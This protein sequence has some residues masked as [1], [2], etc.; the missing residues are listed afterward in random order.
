M[1][2]EIVHG[3]ALAVLKTLA[4]NSIDALVTDP[5]AGIEFMGAEWDTFKQGRLQNYKKQPGG[6]I[7][8]N[9][10]AGA[11]FS[12]RMAAN[13]NIANQKA[14]PK[15]KKCNKYA[16]DHPGRKCE[17]EIPDWQ[18]DHSARQ[19]FISFMRDVMAEALRCIKPGGH[20]LVWA[21]PRT[22][23]WTATALEDAGW[24]IRDVVTHLTGQ[25]F[26][27]SL[28]ID[29]A[30][31]K[32]L[33]AERTERE[34]Y[35]RYK[36]GGTR[37][38]QSVAHQNI[39]LA[40][41]RNGNYTTLPATPEA[42]QWAGYGSALKPAAENWIYCQ[43]PLD[44]LG[45]CDIIV[46]NLEKIR[47]ELLC[48][49]PAKTAVNPSQPTPQPSKKVRASSALSNAPT[50][51]EACHEPAIQTGEAGD[52]LPAMDMSE[53]ESVMTTCLSIVTSWSNILVALSQLESRFTI[54][55]V[56][57]L[58]TD[59]KTLNSLVSKITPAIIIQAVTHPS[60][61]SSPVFTVEILLSG[62]QAKL[63]AI[64]KLTAL[65]SATEQPKE[66]NENAPVSNAGL[67]SLPTHTSTECSAT[68][69]ATTSGEQPT[70]LQTP[71]PTGEKAAASEHWILCR[72]PLA[73]AN[74]ASNV[75]AW[76]TGGLNIDNTR[77][78]ASG[79][80]TRSHQ[81][82]YS[83]SGWRTGHE[84]IDLPAG[85]WPPNFLLS[86]SPL[87]QRVGTKQVKGSAPPGKPSRGKT[88]EDASM[89]GLP[90]NNEY[91][92]YTDADGMETVE[93]WEC[94]PECPVRLLDEQAGER[95]SGGKTQLSTIGFGRAENH[96]VDIPDIREPSSGPVSRFFPV[97]TP[98]MPVAYF[99]KASRRERNAGCEGLPIEAS[100]R[101][102]RM[103]GTPEHGAKHDTPEGNNHPTVK[104]LALMSW[105]VR[106][107]TPPDGTVLDC[108]AG[109]GSTLVACV[110][111]GFHY[112]GIEQSADYVEICKARVA[113]AV[114]NAPVTRQEAQ[115]TALP[116]KVIPMPRRKKNAVS[117]LQLSLFAQEVG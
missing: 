8:S 10:G 41:G 29:K 106:L 117:E 76:G 92:S 82:P 54:E 61:S 97:F 83:A 88:V 13:P 103:P 49:Y 2:D 99:P 46:A 16:W 23:H 19:T 66:S 9:A 39:P 47:S 31:D 35:D 5:P 74:L 84:V 43:K 27:K 101:Y 32:Q 20:A 56:S 7:G 50:L 75:L 91:L 111:E 107:I 51:E 68:S 93:S 34:W 70:E 37:Q 53:S 12:A 69:L 72:K 65:A 79:G 21:L 62:V 100:A 64:Q 96:P 87:C 90:H 108:F 28:A 116:A 113:H 94:A 63:N 15:C 55:T 36:D 3:D 110:Q 67:P 52:S 38:T 14:N 1:R 60:I 58:I 11:D 95:K 24:E 98:D 40:D 45:H 26:P 85:R 102:G 59:L 18:I 4:D 105:L 80:T 104:S 109:S 77:V 48:K 71:S 44:L 78:G 86:H 33:G 114:R 30:I 112:I 57:G 81:A 42:Q 73:A 22:S 89:F 115:Q 6:K 25:G 17:C